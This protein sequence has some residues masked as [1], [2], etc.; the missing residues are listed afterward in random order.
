MSASGPTRG[1]PPDL[2][3][4]FP[5]KPRYV[6][7]ARHTVS[8]LARMRQADEELVEDIRLAV[9]EAC[10]RAVAV[11]EEAGAGPVGVLASVEDGVFT[12]EVFDRGPGPE[13]SVSG[14]PGEIDTSELPFDRAL[15]LPLIRGL[16]EEVGL[17]AREGGGTIVRMS[18]SLAGGPS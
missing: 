1:S 2:D 18:V 15:A 12:V 13:R 14:P 11:N 8:A 17:S 10:T 3:I 7:M 16:V 5:A 9:S 4:E 6:R